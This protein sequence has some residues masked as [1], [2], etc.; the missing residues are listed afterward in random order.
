MTIQLKATDQSSPVVLFGSEGRVEEYFSKKGGRV[1][2][3]EQLIYTCFCA[4]LKF[5]FI[6]VFRRTTPL[7]MEAFVN[8]SNTRTPRNLTAISKGKPQC[9]I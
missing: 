8:A 9:H 2:M 6:N 4:T 7:N 1:E 3:I 5:I